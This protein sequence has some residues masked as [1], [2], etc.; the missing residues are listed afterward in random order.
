M[1]LIMFIKYCKN[2]VMPDTKW[3]N[4]LDETGICT[5]CRFQEVKE[6]IDWKKRKEELKQIFEKYKSK[7]GSNYDCICPVSGGKDSHYI[8]YVVTQEFGLNPLLV[9]FRPT[10]RELT[11]VGRKN[12]DN[13][14]KAFN[15]DC[16]EFSPKPDVYRKMQKVALLELGDASYPAHF[17]I[18]TVPVRVAVEK[19]IPLIIWGENS[20][21]EYGGPTDDQE[22]QYLDPVWLKKY[23]V[24]I[25]AEGHSDY[26]GPEF[27]IKHGIEKKD[28][29]PYI[30]PSEKEL[31]E[32][33]VTG[34]FLGSFVKWD[35]F[36]QLEL[37][38]KWGFSVVDGKSEGTY[39]NF[40]NLDN[41]DQGLHD[42]LKWLKFGYGRTSDHASMEI[43]KKRLTR[44]EGL[45][46]VK[47]F[48]GIIPEQYL[49]EYLQDFEM[50]R[51]DFSNCIDKFTN[52]D[53]FKKDENGN[54]IRDKN[55]N[56]EKINYD[57]VD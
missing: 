29:L 25:K 6:K 37:M 33:G 13:L 52:K 41:K 3:E 44:E 51:N 38:K 16:L 5:A 32:V 31:Q 8:T 28:L 48:E 47:K 12:L 24:S 35:V 19:K 23:G 21:A 22:K 9:S 56:L 4:K 18:F 2:C 27:M 40:E 17:S 1:Y 20:Q 54:L 36:K 55:G 53:L 45:E 46:L 42:Y 26:T 15:V 30:Y 10:Y 57:N 14:K 49:D 50:T 34:I 7:D 11:D 39:T 43:R